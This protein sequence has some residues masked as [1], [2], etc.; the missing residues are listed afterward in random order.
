MP[1]KVWDEITYPVPNFNGCTVEV[2]EW[3]INFMPQ[4]ITDA[5]TY[6][7]QDLSWT[8]WVKGSA[9]NTRRCNRQFTDKLINKAGT[10]RP[11]RTIALFCAIFQ[12]VLWLKVA[13]CFG[14]FQ[15]LH[16]I[17][18]HIYFMNFLIMNWEG[19]V[20][21]KMGDARFWCPSYL[22]AIFKLCS[23]EKFLV[24]FWLVPQLRIH[25][26]QIG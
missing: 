21:C 4:F 18:L 12:V 26:S 10:Y 14:V 5:I 7:C 17:Y 19:G 16:C 1:I 23:E 15:W 9:N 25:P 6:P 20:S 3:I 22:I 8:M 2:W 11:L 24:I 13:R